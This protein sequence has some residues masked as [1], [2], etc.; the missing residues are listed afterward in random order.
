MLKIKLDDYDQLHN[1]V[2]E[3]SIL[4][5]LLDLSR[6]YCRYIIYDNKLDDAKKHI[7]SYLIHKQCK[8]VSMLLELLNRKDFAVSDKISFSDKT[9]KLP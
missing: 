3:I 4:V 5:C 7:D 1:L 2:E 6:S 9:E 8:T